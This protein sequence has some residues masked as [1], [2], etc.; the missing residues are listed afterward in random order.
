M[1]FDAALKGLRAKV[2]RAGLADLPERLEAMIG[3]G[4]AQAASQMLSAAFSHAQACAD[5]CLFLGLAAARLGQWPAA[6]TILGRARQLA[7]ARLAAGHA[8]AVAL[9]RAGQGPQ[10]LALFAEIRARAPKDA[11]LA[12]DHALAL[13][14]F[15]RSPD[16]EAILVETV[17]WAPKDRDAQ[18]NLGVL[19]AQRGDCAGAV[20][21]LTAAIALDRRNALL[22]FNLGNALRDAGDGA[23]ALAAYQGAVELQPDLAA[24]W[25]NKANLEAEMGRHAESVADYARVEGLEPAANLAP[26]RILAMNL[27]PFS[28]A[29]TLAVATAWAKTYADPLAPVARPAVAGDGRIRIGYLAAGL[30]T[31]D[32]TQLAVLAHHDRSRFEVIV[33]FDGDP[34]HRRLERFCALATVRMTRGLSDSELAQ[35]I[36]ADGLDIL[37]DGLGFPKGHRLLTV[38]RRPARIHL[39]WP[40]MTTTGMAAMDGL[41]ADSRTLPPGAEG[42]YRE[43]VYRLPCSYHFAVDELAVPGLPLRPDDGTVRFGCFNTL[44]KIGAESIALFARVLAACPGSRLRVKGMVQSAFDHPRLKDGFAAHGIGPDRLEFLP[45]TAG[46]GEHLAA[47]GELDVAL[48]PVPYN[49]VTTTFESL[50]MGVPVVTLPGQRILDRYGLSLLTEVGFADGI[51]VH[52]DDYVARAV[53]LAADRP[54]RAKLRESLRDRVRASRLNDSARFTREWED[55]LAAIAG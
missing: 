20:E 18:A 28:A 48:D 37:I 1:D 27:A 4:E 54:L 11:G 19:R 9:A 51:A 25:R 43:R 10:S 8:L 21:A 31:L 45:P 33:Y 52:A 17:K 40:P 44:A 13:A 22:R 2:R 6:A 35:L 3:R 30:F 53:R 50:W 24:A 7:P 32:G 42:D 29:D 47:F 26:T 36:A 16:A 15:G 12:N 23:A 46:Y 38:A 41:V 55:L 5:S 39:H 34:A 14:A 49:G